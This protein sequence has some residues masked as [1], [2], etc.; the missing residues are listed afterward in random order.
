MH[1]SM[2]S[3]CVYYDLYGSLHVLSFD[4]YIQYL[5]DIM[6]QPPQAPKS[7]ALIQGQA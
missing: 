4:Y 1:M 3:L 6:A 7:R 5:H 2:L